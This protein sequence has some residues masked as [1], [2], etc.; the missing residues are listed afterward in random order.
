MGQARA[1]R[2]PR[3]VRPGPAAAAP[4][5]ASRAA[6]PRGSGTEASRGASQ[7]A[8]ARDHPRIAP[9]E[10]LASPA[11]RRAVPCHPDSCPTR[12]PP[13]R[14]RAALPPTPL[15]RRF[16]VGRCACA[17]ARPDGSRAGPSFPRQRRRGGDSERRGAGAGQEPGDSGGHT[18]LRAQG[19]AQGCMGQ[20][21]GAVR[22]SGGS[23]GRGGVQRGEWAPAAE[24]GLGSSERMT[25]AGRCRGRR[26]WQPPS[27]PL[28][29]AAL[30]AEGGGRARLSCSQAW[31]DC[32]ELHS[33]PLRPPTH[34][35]LKPRQ[36]T[37]PH[38]SLLAA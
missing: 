3:N 14:G 22:H 18:R 12:R 32:A 30:Q 10:A 1:P 20:G 13:P 31:R 24:V 21:G 35:M 19:G 25:G 23:V 26:G 16:R 2:A 17:T 8:K 4:R 27:C 29:F 9:L 5:T 34:P 15:P 11:P 28:A 6:S 38:S 33:T 7:K 37:A 36:P